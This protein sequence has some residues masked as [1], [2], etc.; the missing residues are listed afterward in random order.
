MFLKKYSMQVYP[1]IQS[2]YVESHDMEGVFIL[3]THLFWFVLK[4]TFGEKKKKRH[5]FPH[6]CF[7]IAG[8]SPS[9]KV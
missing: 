3:L 9:E 8:N 5:F 7:F 6:L 4:V 2:I 1:I